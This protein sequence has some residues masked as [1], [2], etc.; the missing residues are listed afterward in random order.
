MVFVTDG[1]GKAG[2]LKAEADGKTY[3]AERIE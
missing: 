3:T 1:N 2:K